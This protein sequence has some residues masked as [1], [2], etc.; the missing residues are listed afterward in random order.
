MVD[1]IRSR[2][3]IKIL[4][5]TALHPARR[6][7][8]AAAA[9]HGAALLA[10]RRQAQPSQ[11]PLPGSLSSLMTCMSWKTCSLS[12][13]WAPGALNQAMAHGQPGQRCT[14]RSSSCPRRALACTAAHM[15]DPYVTWRQTAKLPMHCSSRCI[16]ACPP[17]APE[18]GGRRG[19]PGPPQTAGW[20]AGSRGP[21]EVRAAGWGASSTT[22]WGAGSFQFAT[23]PRAP[24]PVRKRSMTGQAKM[25]G[26]SCAVR[27]D[28]SQCRRLRGQAVTLV[29]AANRVKKFNN[30]RVIFFFIYSPVP[31]RP[32]CD[33]GGGG[34]PATRG[35]PARW[36]RAETRSSSTRRSGSPNS[37]GLRITQFPRQRAGKRQTKQSL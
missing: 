25:W 10:R 2:H 31:G 26:A 9:K 30:N 28:P 36:L 37:S 27:T 11:K 22:S 3:V 13:C 24:E 15:A 8:A 16:S 18:R 6:R 35:A 12:R 23:P 17:S 29:R 5:S 7:L 14:P 21:P 33:A 1:F 32:G 34:P 19:Q 4:R 20:G